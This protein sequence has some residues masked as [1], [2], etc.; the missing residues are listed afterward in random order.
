[1]VHE[2]AACDWSERFGLHNEDVATAYNFK[3]PFR[4]L[5]LAAPWHIQAALLEYDIY[6]VQPDGELLSLMLS[7]DSDLVTNMAQRAVQLLDDRTFPNAEQDAIANI[8]SLGSVASQ[9]IQSEE[10]SDFMQSLLPRCRA[11]YRHSVYPTVQPLLLKKWRHVTKA[12]VLAVEPRTQRALEL[13][14]RQKWALRIVSLFTPWASQLKIM[15]PLMLCHDPTQ[16]WVDL[17]GAARF[18]TLRARCLDL[19]KLLRISPG[20]LPLTEDSLRTFLNCLRSSNAS[21]ST[22]QRYWK[23]LKYFMAK[24]HEL[25]CFTDALKEKKDAIRNEMVKELLKESKK[26]VVPSLKIVEALE[27]GT[28]TG[29]F[30]Q[31]HLCGVARFLLGSSG[32]FSDGQHVVLANVAEHGDTIEVRAWQTKTMSLLDNNTK[33]KVLIAPKKSFSGVPWWQGFLHTV[34]VISAAEQFEGADYLLPALTRCRGRFIPRPCKH[35]QGISALRDTLR[36]LTI[37]QEDT[38]AI[39]WHSFRVFMADWACRAD[40]SRDRRRYIGQWSSESTADQYVRSHRNIITAIWDEVTNHDVFKQASHQTDR[41]AH[42]N[43]TGDHYFP[44]DPQD[45]KRKL[46][47]KGPLAESSEEVQSDEAEP[48]LMDVP[49]GDLFVVVAKRKTGSPALFSVHLFTR[50]LVGV[51]CSWAPPRERYENLTK[52]DY[53]D[54]STGTAHEKFRLCS[55]CFKLHSLPADWPQALPFYQHKDDETASDSSGGSSCSSSASSN[56]T[57]SESE[58]FTPPSLS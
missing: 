4:T 49:V 2:L 41:Q 21:P 58:A 13:E 5:L 12:Q 47:H 11:L 50:D 45:K 56:D 10:Y 20:L 25:T 18:G 9:G 52:Q 7:N 32:R 42:E 6:A 34:S 27:K 44:P 19:E 51:G 43:I 14:L 33:P 55:K 39:T 37:S 40:I 1:M 23:T 15:R 53:I 29:T 24:Y 3:S 48:V 26:A 36:T 54:Q 8:Q 17:L 31:R 46:S 57:A 35:S 22:I 28:A 38:S 16:E 30:C